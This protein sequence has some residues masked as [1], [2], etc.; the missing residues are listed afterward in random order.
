L[1]RKLVVEDQISE[2]VGGGPDETRD[3]GLFSVFSRVKDAK[4]IPTVKE[5]LLQAIEEVK[6]TPV[7]ADR[8]A[9]IK[10]HNKYEFAMGLRNADHVAN[11][12]CHI[13]SLTNN[14]ESVNAIHALYDRVTPDD[15]MRVAKKYF[16]E[17]NR[18]VLVLT[19]QAQEVKQ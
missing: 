7:S 6:T 8:L 17:Q 10:S 16:G 5:A 15:I 14:P 3:P 12:M 9:S 4:N 1:Y 2:S 13:I 18:T 11:T 19:Q